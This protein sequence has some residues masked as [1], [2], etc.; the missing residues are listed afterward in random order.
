MR[1]TI[2]IKS[3]HGIDYRPDIDGLRAIAVL[4]V[5]IFHAYPEKIRGGFI[6]VDIFFVISGY[7]ISSV[8]YQDMQAGTFSI[9]KFYERRVR[10]IFPALIATLI[11]CFAIG[12]VIL[13][14]HEF[15]QLG[16]NIAGGAVFISNLL[17]WKE[18]GYFDSLAITK[19]LLH[20]WS[21]GVE[22]QFYIFW[23]IF[24]YVAVKRKW[25]VLQ[26]TIFVTVL[27]FIANIA[28]SRIDSI[29][30]FYAPVTRFWEL[31]CGAL[32]AWSKLQE[33]NT[34]AIGGNSF[35]CLLGIGMIGMSAYQINDTMIF[36]GWVALFPVAGA[37]LVIASNKDGLINKYILSNKIIVWI[38]LISYPLYLWHW[39]L[40]SFAAIVEGRLPDAH[41][42]SKALIIA[43][44]LSWLTYKFIEKPLRFGKH[45]KNKV[46]GLVTMMV[47]VGAIGAYTY[48]NNGLV[49]FKQEPSLKLFKGEV[50]HPPYDHYL[51]SHF[52]KCTPEYLQQEA[53][54]AK[55]KCYQ[56]KPNGP[57]NLALIGDSHAEHLFIGLAE[58]LPN[59]NIVFYIKPETPFIDNIHFKNIYEYVLNNNSITEIVLAMNWNGKIGRE[60]SPEEF[61]RK[62][63]ETTAKISSS[64]KILFI[65]N[66]VPVF[67][68]DPQRCVSI[69][70]PNKEQI[71]TEKLTFEYYTNM[72]NRVASST[73]NTY[74]INT[75]EDFC[76]NGECAMVKNDTILYRDFN[77][78]NIEGSQYLGKSILQKTPLL[79]Q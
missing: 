53:T 73:P 36:P 38:G 22:E 69:R 71:C 20:L 52:Y 55:A 64:G 2:Q 65:T 76:F 66:D 29:A 62:L 3:K 28:C 37:A 5:V 21:L 50:G 9:L 41:V 79:R 12:W 58:A 10:R 23:P 13:L 42:R 4:L 25:N 46:L 57:I 77:H 26:V 32:L 24:F 19:P 47:L 27:S 14:P 18:S 51:S 49:F 16:G 35:L 74:V 33:K 11:F 54:N 63:L 17:Y 15:K 34:W 30:A 60:K 56:S 68:F 39:P 8:L 31:Q 75:L 1:S 6:G 45:A 67:S 40:L 72:L 7:L 43:L 44:L 61:E 48:I 59:K 70:W 78:L